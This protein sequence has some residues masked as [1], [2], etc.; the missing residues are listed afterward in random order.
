MGERAHADVDAHQAA[1]AGGQ[2]GDADV[3]VAAVGDHDDV[4]AEV[5]AVLRQQVGQGVGADLLLALDEHRHADA[6]VVAERAD[7]GQVGH[8]PGLVVGGAAAEE[9]AV[10]LGRLEGRR[11]PLGVVVLGLHVVVGVEQHRRPA[12]GRG[13]AG[14]HGRRAAVLAGA[15]DADV[16]EGLGAEQRGHRL[17]AAL[18]LR[19]PRGVGADRL[20]PDEVL[21]VLADPGQLGG[22]PG[23]QLGDVHGPDPRWFVSRRAGRTG[24]HTRAAGGSVLQP[25]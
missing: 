12:L 3:P 8:D 20:D 19:R 9:P 24:C 13:L 5:L 4:G 21:E 15:D 1:Q 7:R 11:V 6:E 22:D 16:L 2:R 14:Q 17:G 25:S 10:A 18:H 23:A